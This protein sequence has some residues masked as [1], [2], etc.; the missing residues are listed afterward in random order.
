[1]GNTSST[2]I[3]THARTYGECFSYR[4]MSSN[5]SEADHS[6]IVENYSQIQTTKTKAP[7]P[8]FNVQYHGRWSMVYPKGVCPVARVGH[9]FCYDRVKDRIII[10]YGRDINGNALNDVWILDLN[11]YRWQNHL[12]TAL[13][14]RYGCAGCLVGREFFIVGG[15]NNFNFYIDLHCINIDTGELRTFEYPGE[16]PDPRTNAIFFFKNG[17]FVMWGGC[18]TYNHTFS[19]DAFILNGQTQSWKRVPAQV[20]GRSA[21]SHCE[22]K[23]K[24]FIYGS[25]QTDD[26]LLEF[27]EATG[28]FIAITCTGTAPLQELTRATLVSADEFIFLIGGQ[29]ISSHMHLYALDVKRKWWFAFHIRPDGESL[30]TAD[31]VVNKLG[32]FML[33]REYDSSIIYRESTRELISTLG[34]LMTEPPPVFKISIGEALAQLHLR[35]DMYEMFHRYTPPHH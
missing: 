33:P 4:L 10:A 7:I 23:G 28:K 34:S 11:G 27:D 22:H 29:N 21:P 20:A 30:T 15:V 1:M 32:L 25:S 17:S 35:N 26:G 8:L 3:E 14:P 12:R 18:K 16:V 24:H 9:V 5:R 13:S 6:I 31:G 19:G 2:Q